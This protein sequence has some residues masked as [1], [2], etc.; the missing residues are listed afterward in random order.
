MDSLDVL[1]EYIC[2]QE[3]EKNMNMT[4]ENIYMVVMS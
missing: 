4:F 3:I 2:E 1:R